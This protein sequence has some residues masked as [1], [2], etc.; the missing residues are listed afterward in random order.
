MLYYSTYKLSSLFGHSNHN[1]TFTVTYTFLFHDSADVSKQKLTLI[2][3]LSLLFEFSNHPHKRQTHR[4]IA[5]M[6]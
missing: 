3:K 4:D 2:Y 6:G 5:L 1:L